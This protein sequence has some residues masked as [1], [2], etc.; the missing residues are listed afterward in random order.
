MNIQRTI[1]YDSLEYAGVT[2]LELR[3]VP[4]YD[5]FYSILQPSFKDLQLHY[6]DNDSFVLNFTEGNGDNEH[7]DLSNLDPPI[8]TKNKIPDK[9]KHEFGSR[10][11]KEFISL[12]PKTYSLVTH[13]QSPFKDYPNKTKEKGIK[14]CKKDKREEYYNALMYNTQ[15]TIRIQKVDD[16]I[17]TTKTNKI[18]LNTF[19]DYPHD[20]NLYIF[21]RTLVNKIKKTSLD[22]DKNQLA[23]NILELPINE[24]R[25]LFK[26]AIK[27]NN[28]L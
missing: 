26:A 27:L 17:T 10:I 1:E 18:S 5:V 4:K 23:N 11:T 8:K 9:I 12:S 22:L 14:N 7:M 25:E 21:K 6:M 24:D 3:K 16:N 19:D 15:R 20:E 28:E 2:I 13:G